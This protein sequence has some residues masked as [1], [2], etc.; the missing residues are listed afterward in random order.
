M[1]KQ[2]GQQKQ[3]QQFVNAYKRTGTLWCRVNPPALLES[4]E[5]AGRGRPRR[6]AMQKQEHVGSSDKKVSA[7]S[8]LL[9]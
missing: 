2:F 8:S 7:V 4:E 9:Q 6:L 5:R 1:Q 3:T